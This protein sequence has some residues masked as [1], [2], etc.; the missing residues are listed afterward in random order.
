MLHAHYK[1][2]SASSRFLVTVAMCT[3]AIKINAAVNQSFVLLMR[4]V[5]QKLVL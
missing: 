2:V 1:K 4:K 3:L 5:N